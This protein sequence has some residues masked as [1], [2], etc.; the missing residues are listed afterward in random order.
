MESILLGNEHQVDENEQD[1]KRVDDGGG[2]IIVGIGS[3]I[4]V[5]CRGESLNAILTIEGDKKAVGRGLEKPH[6]M[7]VSER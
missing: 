7:L 4:D 6:L 3:A 2:S 5:I 1:G